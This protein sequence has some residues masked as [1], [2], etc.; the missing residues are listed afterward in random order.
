M[1]TVQ[2]H[3]RIESVAPLRRLIDTDLLESR[4]LQRVG[5][6]RTMRLEAE[7]DAM[8]VAPGM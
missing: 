3:V 8:V 2:Y 4:Y 5:S 6:C 1:R 7:R